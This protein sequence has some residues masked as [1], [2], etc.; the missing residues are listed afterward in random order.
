MQYTPQQKATALAALATGDSIRSVSRRLGISRNTLTVWRAELPH[1]PVAEPQKNALGEQ[2]YGY[3]EESIDTLSAQV[4]FARDPAWLRQQ[5]AADLAML[6]GVMF[7]KTWRMLAALQSGDS[8][9]A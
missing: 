7:D 5:N 3:L 6:Y 9:R 2:L 4:R 8:E 1:T